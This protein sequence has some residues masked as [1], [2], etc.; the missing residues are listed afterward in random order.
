M[1]TYDFQCPNGHVFEAHQSY[2]EYDNNK[3]ERCGACG[4]SATRKPT[5]PL[6]CGVKEI[7]TLGQLAEHN[8]KQN[9]HKI[10]E[11][12]HKEKEERYRKL[13]DS[14]PPGAKVSDNYDQ[15]NSK[16]A[17]DLKKVV[18]STAV[19]NLNNGKDL[20]TNESEK[21]RNYIQTGEKSG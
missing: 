4:R 15:T 5:T 7:K 17:F 10:Q 2:A 11:Q 13:R 3:Q 9:W 16:P 14:L 12:E 20:T 8:T 6:Y 19:D 18:G 1:P 21:I